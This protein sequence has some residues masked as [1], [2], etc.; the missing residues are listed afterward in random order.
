MYYTAKWQEGP[1]SIYVLEK[2]PSM[3]YP[4]LYTE[5]Y[6]VQSKTHPKITNLRNLWYRDGKKVLPLFTNTYLLWLW[7][8]VIK[9]MVI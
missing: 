8:G 4:L 3:M 7:L 6:Y 2:R 5:S 9:M 1:V